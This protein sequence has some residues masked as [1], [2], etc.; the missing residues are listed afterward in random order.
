MTYFVDGSPYSFL[1]TH[2]PRPLLNVGWLSA[3]HPYP[4][5]TIPEELAAK[6][7]RL[8][9]DGVHRTRGLHRC[10]LCAKPEGLSWPSPVSARDDEG[11]FVVGGAEIRVAD[12]AGVTF[13]APDMIIHYVREHGYRPPD[14][15]LD[16]LSRSVQR[17]PRLE[18][19]T[20]RLGGRRPDR[21]D[22]RVRR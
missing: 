12:L 3:E 5:G 21:A 1:E 20:Y 17:G 10:E 7:A 8:C 11:E 6:L 9:R 15:F 13:A 22:L 14:E 19:G 18:L 4:A 2:E 16:A